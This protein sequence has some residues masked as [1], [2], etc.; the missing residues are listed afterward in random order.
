MA[1]LRT[2]RTRSSAA[3][4]PAYLTVFLSLSLTIILSLVLTLIEGARIYAI[5]MQAEVVVQTAMDSC[6]A[7]YN[8]A[9]QERYDLF[10]VDTSYGDG[11]GSEAE[12]HDH[13]ESYIKKNLGRSSLLEFVGARDL[14]ALSVDEVDITDSRYACDAD[15]ESVREQIYAYMTAGPEAALAEGFL[16]LFESV[17]EYDDDSWEA[18]FEESSSEFESACRDVEDEEDE[19]TEDGEGSVRTE[20][21]GRSAG[22]AAMERLMGV[23]DEV[24]GVLGSAFLSQV[25]REDV[26]TAEA[27]GEN[28][29]VDRIP[30]Y[31]TAYVPENSHDYDEA[32]S[33]LVTQYMLE[34]CGHYGEVREGSALQYE[35]EY[36]LFGHL[37][38]EENLEQMTARLV[39]LRAAADL[40][41]IEDV[42]SCTAVAD[43]IAAVLAFFPGIPAEVTRSLILTIWA[44]AEAIAD[45]R[46]LYAGG[47]VP[48]VKS[49]SN[50]Q[51]S[52][53]G[54]FSS[55][56]G[57]SSGGAGLDYD[58]YLRIFLLGQNLMDGSG[59]LERLLS[60]MELDVAVAQDGTPV[61]MD[62]CLD[63]MAANVQISSGFGYRCEV[64]HEI[65]YN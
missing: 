25:G 20:T 52:W 55:G 12:I 19:R 65:T 40:Y 6:L 15:Y 13:L 31:G 9:L 39:L 8:R 58:M 61:F 62:Y 36:L 47:S 2:I 23:L 3:E 51:T 26:S 59:T 42:G 4:T 49:G 64:R 29:L 56:G 24:R 18:A 48:L 53:E 7:E 35:V 34:K 28:L 57:G 33:L 44:Y 21:P 22:R 46:T 17:E 43:G 41:A 63:A 32:G 50:W 14:T 27:Y 54:L 16:G 5:R 37:S 30:H 11:A 1:R 60:V 38:D 45:V 10:Y